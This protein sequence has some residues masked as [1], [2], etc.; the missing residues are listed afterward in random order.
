MSIILID[1]VLFNDKGEQ[2]TIRYNNCIFFLVLNGIS[3][4]TGLFYLYF[5]F[6]IPYYQNSSNSLSLFLNIFHLISNSFY[7][8]IFFE[9]YIYEPTILSLTIKIITMFNPLII[10]CIY[11]WSACLTHNLYV[12][13]Y[14]YTHNMDKRIKFYKYL[15]FL[16]M[17]I[18][19]LYTLFNIHYNESQ[20]LSKSFSFISNYNISFLDF[21]YISGLI[22]IIYI[23]I[24]LYYVINK[25]EDFITVNE[26]QESEEKNIKI[27]NLFN[28]VIARNISFI[29][30]FLI[31]FTPTNIIM[32]LKY[33]LGKSNIKSYFIDYM[34]IMLISFNGTFLFLVRLFDPL[35]RNFIINLLMFNR[36]FISSYEEY[37]LK[38]RGRLNESL[39]EEVSYNVHDDIINDSLSEI[40]TKIIDFPEN[41]DNNK[42]K[43]Y[44]KF[45]AKSF[46]EIKSEQ[47]MIKIEPKHNKEKNYSTI[48]TKKASSNKNIEMNSFISNSKNYSN[49]NKN[50][51]DYYVKN[52]TS[53]N[54]KDDKDN[55]SNSRSYRSIKSSKSSKSSKSNKSNKSIISSGMSSLNSINKKSLNEKDEESSDKKENIINMKTFNIRDN[56]DYSTNTKSYLHVNSNEKIEKENINNNKSNFGKLR[57][58]TICLTKISNQ[59]LVNRANKFSNKNKTSLFIKSFRKNKNY[60][61]NTPNKNLSNIRANSSASHFFQRK[62]L[63]PSVQKRRSNSK[64]KEEF[65]HEEI[66][67]FALMNYHLELNENLLRMIAISI[68]INECRIYD[69]IKEYKKYYTLTIPWENKDFYKQTTLF[70]EYNDET[71]PSW[72]G[73]K[74][75]G[76][77]TNIQ[78]KIMSYCP[79]V[80]HHIRLIDNISIDD[81]LSSLDP[82]V[83]IK[84]IMKVSGGRGNNSL[85]CTWDKKIIV[86]TINENERQ[87]LIDK[88]IIDFHCMMKEERSILS[89]IYGVFKIELGDKGSINVIIQRNMN[90]LPL[91]T[92]ILTFDFKGS[93][94]DRQTISKY[95]LSLEKEQ[96]INK[97]KNKVLK[98]I[99][100]G[101]I[102]M[103]FELE[104]DDLQKISNIID[105]DSSFL[106]NA[107]IT[108]YSLVVFIHK[109]R[110]EDMVHNKW[111]SRIFASKDKK[112]IFNFTIVDFLGTFNFEK[113]GEKLAKSL[114]G[115]IKKLKDTNFSVLEPESYA[116][117]FRKFCKKIIIDG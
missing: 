109:Y 104:S 26:Y 93:T 11:Y 4:F 63:P 21:F 15:L 32:I 112:Y 61:N 87:I 65:Y 33:F 5:Y 44:K 50:D 94:V 110:N 49:L 73:L 116:K 39:T 13:Y 37:L 76:R 92:R 115:Y 24:K 45:Y 114:V 14:N 75:D 56:S 99:D 36:E 57:S 68:S 108:D 51:E 101:I 86:K 98:D 72:I 58:N 46:G 82:L 43:R 3:I 111:G 96:L 52:K 103:K 31:T 64:T 90:D 10:L 48:F 102:G 53:E 74:K 95:D 113:K 42:N 2:R 81:M 9:F 16:I 25:K 107:E 40:K 29:C 69:D 83:N 97:Y 71:I 23:S 78:F 28:S 47:N 80:F 1:D 62:F 20:L 106:Q 85:I 34:V 117:R 19:Y 79:F 70:K 7:F 59:D 105:S 91:K 41:Y 30:Y 17:V 8:L 38:E 6:K 54:Y 89:R 60:N 22:I 100:L 77:F 88:M 18:F 12:T 66:S 84:K 27:K 67:S 55:S 35:M